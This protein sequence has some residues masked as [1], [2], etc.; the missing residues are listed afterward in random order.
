MDADQSSVAETG[1]IATFL[2]FAAE[3]PERYYAGEEVGT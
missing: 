3:L 2:S 1:Q